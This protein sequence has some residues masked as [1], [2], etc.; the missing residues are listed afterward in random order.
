MVKA[1]ARLIQSSVGMPNYL[2]ML[3]L[4]RRMEPGFSPRILAVPLVNVSNAAA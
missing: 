2:G 3:A 4:L 1:S